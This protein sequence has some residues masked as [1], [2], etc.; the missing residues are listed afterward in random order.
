MK[1]PSGPAKRSGVSSIIR[2]LA[3]DASQCGEQNVLPPLCRRM[4]PKAE[5][6]QK[7]QVFLKLGRRA[8]IPMKS[9][10]SKCGRDVKFDPFNLSGSKAIW[11]RTPILKARFLHR[12]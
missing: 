8:K 4:R 2:Q 3:N 12:F 9:T 6:L 10:P 7:S 1:S 11:P 5:L